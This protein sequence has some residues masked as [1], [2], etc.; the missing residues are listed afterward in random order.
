M[1]CDGLSQ[2]IDDGAYPGHALQVGMHDQ[3]VAPLDFD[4]ASKH[5]H[6][7][8]V[9]LGRKGMEHPDARSRHQYGNGV[10]IFTRNGDFAQKFAS[11]VEVGMVGINVPIPVPVSYHSFGGWKRS[12]FGDLDQYG[13]DG[14]RFYTRTKKVTKRWPSGGSV[15]DQSFVIPTLR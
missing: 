14:I 1:P 9:G 8:L 12:G 5:T 10:A 13:L 11:E 7:A 3:P 2:E 15:V 6:E 4:L